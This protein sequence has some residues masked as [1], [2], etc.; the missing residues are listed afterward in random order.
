MLIRISSKIDNFRF[1][2]LHF[3]NLIVSEVVDFQN[4]I[5]L[6]I[7]YHDLLHNSNEGW[8]S[9]GSGRRPLVAHELANSCP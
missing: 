6:E 3:S 9:P 1:P 2:K 4:Y 7:I 8:A 5:F